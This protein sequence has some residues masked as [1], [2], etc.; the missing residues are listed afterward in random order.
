MVRHLVVSGIYI[1]G[2]GIAASFIPKLKNLS[3]SIFASSGI[4][5]VF[6]GFASQQAFSNIIGGIFIMVFKPFR[7][8]DLLRFPGK[9]MTGI[10]ED[11]TLRH[12]VIKSFEN[13]RII[14]P[15]SVI[16]N[17]IIENANIIDEK[18][19]KFFEIGIS[20][21]SN[22]DKAMS[23]IKAEAFMHKNFSDNRTLKEMNDGVEPIPVKIVSFGESSVNLKAWIW[24]DD[25]NSGF[26]LIWDLNYIIKKRFE[27]EGINI[28]YPQR[29]VHIRREGGEKDEEKEKGTEKTL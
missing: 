7:V 21:D 17:E 15:N 27:E 23:I 12:T 6:I 14:M 3:T 20:Y 24:V 2:I 8:G 4:V 28:P 9:E 25:N 16:G 13:K 18:I 22:V 19:C 1:I 10:V 11:I 26:E 5:A 29:T